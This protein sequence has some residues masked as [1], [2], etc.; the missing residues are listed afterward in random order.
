MRPKLIGGKPKPPKKKGPQHRSSTRPSQPQRGTAP[1]P[2]SGEGEGGNGEGEGEEGA[3]ILEGQ[4]LSTIEDTKNMKTE[5]LALPT[6]AE[7]TGDADVSR[8]PA[9]PGEMIKTQYTYRNCTHT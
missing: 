7:P 8:L 4:A 2:A 9:S 5:E 6:T 3:G 1:V